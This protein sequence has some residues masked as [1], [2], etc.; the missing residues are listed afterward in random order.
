M[1]KRIKKITVVTVTYNSVNEIRKTI[2]SVINQTYLDIEYIIIDGGSTDG[3]LKIIKDFDKKI[4]ILISEP[5]KGIYDAMNKGI[6]LASGDYLIFM[7][8]GDVFAS[9]NVISD[10]IEKIEERDDVIYGN[11]VRHTSVMDYIDYPKPLDFFSKGMPLDHQAVFV[12]SCLLKDNKFS[13]TYKIIS[14]FVQLRKLYTEGYNY[15]YINEIIAVRDHTKGETHD[16]W[17][18]T[19]LKELARYFG[20]DK[21]V[22][23]KLSHSYHLFKHKIIN[24]LLPP[25]YRLKRAE[26]ILKNKLKNNEIEKF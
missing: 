2:L 9:E 11:I 1:G 19:G 13:L 12:R 6:D 14:D 18:K 10:I 15:K 8:S 23:F 4:S 22:R 3:T 21:T 16:N 24:A 5:D 20:Y 17:E 26:K 7:N 25:S